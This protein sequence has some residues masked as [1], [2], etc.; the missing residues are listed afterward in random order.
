MRPMLATLLASSTLALPLPQRATA[1]ASALVKSFTRREAI[2]AGGG[3]AVGFAAG[4]LSNNAFVFYATASD[5]PSSFIATQQTIAG[6][7]I[8]VADGDTIRVRHNPYPWPLPAPSP[9]GKKSTTTIAVRVIGVDAPEI[10]KFG[11]ESQPY[12]EEAKAYATNQLLN[13][14]VR[15]R[16]VAKDRY[17]RLVAEVKYGPLASNDLSN[18]LLRRG[19]AVVYRGRDASYSKEERER[20]DNLESTAQKQRK[21]MWRDGVDSVQLPSEYKKKAK[22]RAKKG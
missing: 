19:L 4:R 12:A 22:A 21:G 18:G 17:G 11:S 2:I 5:L 16:C 8:S 7:V 3:A 20:W 6:Q 14:R 10:G 1:A 13:K 9:K 15:V